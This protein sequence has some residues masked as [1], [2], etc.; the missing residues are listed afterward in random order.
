M[1]K[2][3]GDDS[4][5]MLLA[6][7]EDGSDDSQ[8]PRLGKCGPCGPPDD[9]QRPAAGF[10]LGW[11]QNFDYEEER[12]TSE[13]VIYLSISKFLNYMTAFKWVCVF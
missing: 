3:Y 8:R 2:P 6:C 7:V 13:N 1:K 12:E 9:P 10:P 11:M 4:K 5:T